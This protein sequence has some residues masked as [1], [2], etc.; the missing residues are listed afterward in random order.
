MSNRQISCPSWVGLS[1]NDVMRLTSLPGA[2]HMVEP[3]VWCDLEAG[4][5]DRHVALGQDS[6]DGVKSTEWWVWWGDHDISTVAPCP[7]SQPDA[8]SS[9]LGKE[10]SEPCLLPIDHPGRHSFQFWTED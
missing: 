6:F 3:H 7:A 5:A 9:K 8:S 4:H 2:A 1:G 10:D